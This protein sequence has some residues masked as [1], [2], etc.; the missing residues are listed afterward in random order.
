MTH[1]QGPRPEDGTLDIESLPPCELRIVS[2][3]G[4]TTEAD[5]WLIPW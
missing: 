5:W 2:E 1:G 4:T 3:P